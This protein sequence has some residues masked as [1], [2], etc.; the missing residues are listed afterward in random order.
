MIEIGAYHY[1]FTSFALFLIGLYMMIDNRNL[2][3]KVIGLNFTQISVYLMLVT[4]GYVDG[5]TPPIL[6]LEEPHSNP[7]VH[8]LVLTAIVVGV[9]L[10]AL[11][12]ALVIRL[13]TE[14][15]TLDAKEIE[16]QIA[17]DDRTASNRGGNDE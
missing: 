4:I 16:A 12:L 9:A 17:A 15:G 6:G 14:F 5:A 7:L 3:K 13:Y 10:T 8:V 2:I 1:Y 11:A